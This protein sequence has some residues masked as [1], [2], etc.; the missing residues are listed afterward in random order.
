VSK[1][2]ERPARCHLVS[3]KREL[4]RKMGMNHARVLQIEQAT[5]L[6]LKSE[7]ETAQLLEYD[8]SISMVPREGGKA[9]GAL[10]KT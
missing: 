6:E 3:K 10:L 9:F 8:V 2:R 1:K 4:A 7:L 5:N